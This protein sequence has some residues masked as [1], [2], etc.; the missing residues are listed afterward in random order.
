MENVGIYQKFNVRRRDGRDLPGGD[1]ANAAYFV[2]DVA[3]DPNAAGTLETYSRE[4][5]AEAPKLA[6]ELRRLVSE[7]RSGVT[8]GPLVRALRGER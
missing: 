6:E 1:R 8:D 3:N 7:L 2:I 5:E 4:C